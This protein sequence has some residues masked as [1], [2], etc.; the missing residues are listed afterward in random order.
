MVES[1]DN[2]FRMRLLWCELHGQ[3]I[4]QH[5]DTDKV[6]AGE[7]VVKLVKGVV[8]TDSRGGYDAVTR[9]ESPMLGLSNMRAALQAF[10]VRESLERTLTELRWTASDYDLGDALTKKAPS[11]RAGLLQF[12]KTSV[13]SIAFDPSFQSARKNAKAG[14]SAL[15][16]LQNPS[17]TSTARSRSNPTTSSTEKDFVP[18]QQGHLE[19]HQLMP[20]M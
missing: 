2:N 12:L 14:R 15:Q 19:A 6:S 11:C 10:Q 1:E 4:H 16:T 7:E 5:R 13:W 20:C 8:T 3:S 17:S 18:M 9:H